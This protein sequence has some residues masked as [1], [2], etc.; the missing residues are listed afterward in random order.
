[1]NLIGVL[2]A[3]ASLTIVVLGLPAQ[4]VKSYRGKNQKIKH[5]ENFRSFAPSCLLE[6][7]GEY[8][9]IDRPFPYMLFALPVK[10]DKIRKIPA[11]VHKGGTLRTQT[12]TKEDNDIFYEVIK[13]FYKL[14]GISMIL[15]TS[16]NSQEPIVETPEN[17]LSTF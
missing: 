1:M 10:S 6:K 11:V 16:F 15:N 3:T 7:A 5:R 2:A 14:T 9:E 13:E 8:F 4:I 12:V 17:A